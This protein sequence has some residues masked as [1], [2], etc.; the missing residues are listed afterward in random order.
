MQ[1]DA[2]PAVPP[3]PSSDENRVDELYDVLRHHRRRAI[4][5]EVHATD[6]ALSNDGLAERIIRQEGHRATGGSPD[7][8]VDSVRLSLHHTHLPK[9]M[10]TNLVEYDERDQTVEFR[11]LTGEG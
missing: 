5:R 9:L 7:D 4:L 6:G 8:D 2:F 3:P 11:T 1:N 10:G